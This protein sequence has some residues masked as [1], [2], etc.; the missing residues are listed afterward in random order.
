MASE[1]VRSAFADGLGFSST[2]SISLVVNASL[3][4]KTVL[5]RMRRTSIAKKNAT[6]PASL[7]R[8]CAL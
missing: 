1:T 5:A 7:P 2:Y 6:M 8:F 3:R 4:K